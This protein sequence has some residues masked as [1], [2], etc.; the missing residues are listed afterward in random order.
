MAT[1]FVGPCYYHGTC[2]Y[3]LFRRQTAQRKCL[4]SE[5]KKYAIALL[6]EEE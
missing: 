6:V 3:R 2:L 4:L 5:R 1:N